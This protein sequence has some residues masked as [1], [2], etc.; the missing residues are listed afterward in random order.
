MCK[1]FQQCMLK[2]IQDCSLSTTDFCWKERVKTA[3]NIY[4]KQ[5]VRM[6]IYDKLKTDCH[7]SCCFANHVRCHPTDGPITD[8]IPF[9]VC[10]YVCLS[11]CSLSVVWMFHAD[12]FT[13]NQP[14]YLTHLLAPH[15]RGRSLD[16]HRKHS[17]SQPTV[18]TAIGCRG[19][20]Y[21]ASSMWNKLP[22]EIHNSSSLSGT[23][24]RRIIL[25]THSLRPAPRHLP[26]VN[27]RAS[28]SA[29][30]PTICVL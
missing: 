17:L 8:C 14:L 27:V 4:R 19:F 10:L 12:V 2:H 18:S 7:F 16:S 3:V 15:T 13:F 6:R 30:R 25:P 9:S 23:L 28:D 22:L 11:V 21:A 26:R 20:S 5:S 24:L 29:H 1:A